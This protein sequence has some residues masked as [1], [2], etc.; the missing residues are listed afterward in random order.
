MKIAVICNPQKKQASTVVQKLLK[1]FPQKSHRLFMDRVLAYELKRDDL[2]LSDEEMSRHADLLVVLGGDGTLLNAVKRIPKSGLPVL[3]VNLGSMGFLT[4]FRPDEFLK[5]FPDLL[6]KKYAIDERMMLEV[7]LKR[8]TGNEKTY[9]ALNDA[10]ITKGSLARMLSLQVYVN[11][12]NVTTYKADGLIVATPTGSTA[13]SLSSGGP[14]VVPNCSA[15]ILTPICPHTLSNR[16]LVIEQDEKIRIQLISSSE[17]VGLT[18]DGQIGM[19][20]NEGDW[21]NVRKG[22]RKIPL[23][24]FS[25]NYF[26]VLQEKLG[27]RGSSPAT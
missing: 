13:H 5:K 27:W 20:L 3:G 15:M 14:I 9:E 23:V 16:P 22:R 26:D 17:K 10:V 24:R 12:D 2:Y 6:R 21:V 18:L 11:D 4:E 1:F 7:T 19:E 25:H 8:S